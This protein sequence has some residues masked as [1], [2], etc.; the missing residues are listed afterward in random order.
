MR[1]PVTA[2]LVHYEP[3]AQVDVRVGQPNAATHAGVA[4]SAR[5]EA[6]VD[7]PEQLIAQAEV[8]TG[9]VG[10]GERLLFDGGI[11]GLLSQD[12]DAL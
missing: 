3:E 5:G 11:D 2:H 7:L 8:A 1:G 9:A 6:G 10:V 4:E 12:T